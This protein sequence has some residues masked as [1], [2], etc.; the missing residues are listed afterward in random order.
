MRPI[1]GRKTAGAVVPG[2]TPFA[3]RL[4]PVG[5]GCNCT[6]T[7]GS[8]PSLADY[9]PLGLD[10]TAPVPGFTPFA[11]GLRPVGAGCRCTCTRVYTLRWQMTHLGAG[12]NCTCTRVYALRR[13]ITPRW[14]WMQ[15]HLYQCLHPSL[16][17][18]APLGLDAA[19]PVGCDRI[20]LSATCCPRSNV[21]PRERRSI[22]WVPRPHWQLG[23]W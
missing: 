16:A 3:G 23:F 9:A 13:Q 19:T 14:G 21:D 12:C 18:C 2:L 8:R 11:D 17:D 4:R 5:A 15:L 1:Q 7:R 10:A 22:V 6:C 20:G